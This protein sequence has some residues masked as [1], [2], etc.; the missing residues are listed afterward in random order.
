MR[1]AEPIRVLILSGANNH[2]WKS[3]TPVLRAALEGCPRFRVAGVIEDPARIDAKL[4]EGCDAVL[5][6]WTPFPAVTGKRWEPAVEAAFLA[7]LEGGKGFVSVHAACTAHQDW[8][9]FQKLVA[10]T[11]GLDRTGH[12]AYHPFRVEITDREHPVTRGLGGFWIA[13]ELWHAMAALVPVEARV[14][15]SAFSD[16]AK[17]GSGKVE[18]VLF[19]THRG[20]GRGLNLVL[21]HDAGSMAN[22]GFRT[23][24]L[25]GLEWAVTGEVTVP[26]LADY[27]ATA[28][29][30]TIPSIDV[31]AALRAASAWR[32]GAARKDLFLVE[33][34]VRR[35]TAVPAGGPG[36]PASARKALAAKI[37]GA[38]AGATP[39][40]RDFLLRQLSVVG[41]E[42]EAPAITAFLKEERSAF[43]ARFA[44]ERI[45]GGR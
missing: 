34:A 24:L 40:A 1:S 35:A 42:A 28:A 4:L 6:N 7:W 31:E 27:P 30:A 11:W 36:D 19:E 20:K 2:D 41:T 5:S 25:R 32:H 26:A 39:D 45:R 22:A 21:G 43:M 38:L 15:A 9:E 23:L 29:M 44:L 16:P 8:P 12:G 18:P 37:A 13:D 10:Y 14:L 3:T 17:G 33:E